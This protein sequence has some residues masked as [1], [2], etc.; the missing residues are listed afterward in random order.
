MSLNQYRYT[1]YCIFVEN[2]ETYDNC[3]INKPAK[4]ACKDYEIAISSYIYVM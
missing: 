2:T 1:S 3:N 4:G